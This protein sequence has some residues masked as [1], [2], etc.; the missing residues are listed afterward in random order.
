[1]LVVRRIGVR[2][3]GAHDRPGRQGAVAGSRSAFRLPTALLK[4]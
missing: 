3:C 4:G 2:P 1:M